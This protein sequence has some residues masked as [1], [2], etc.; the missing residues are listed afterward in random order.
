MLR[1]VIGDKSLSSWSLR[2]WMALTHSAIEFEEIRLPLDTDHFY[3][4][5]RNYSPTGRVPV[6]IDGDRVVWDSLAICEYVNELAGGRCWPTDPAMRAHARSV[7]AEMHS[8]LQA[9][10]NQWSMAAV[11]RNLQV[12]LDADGRADVARIDS[13]WSDCRNRYGDRGPWL[14]G[15]YSIADAMYAPVALRFQTYGAELSRTAG[16][17][18]TTVLADPLLQRWLREAAHEVEFE[19][20][21]ATH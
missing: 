20:R 16:A 15:E 2:P 18:Y 10:R 14:F 7:S 17:Y 6:L 9:L 12:A 4:E 8:G 13:L 1:L 19:G 3:R 21:L 5:I 11:L